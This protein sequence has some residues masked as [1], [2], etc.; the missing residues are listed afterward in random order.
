[1]S[2]YKE[3]DI[4]VKIKILEILFEMIYNLNKAGKLKKRVKN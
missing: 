2:L 4:S 1:M 3:G